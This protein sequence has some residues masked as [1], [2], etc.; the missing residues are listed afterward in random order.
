MLHRLLY[1]F[2]LGHRFP[3]IVIHLRL[4]D[5]DETVCQTRLFPKDGIRDSQ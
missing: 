2:R 5:P 3:I 4:R 1:T